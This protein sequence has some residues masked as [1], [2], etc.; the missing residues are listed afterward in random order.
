M[1]RFHVLT[2]AVFAALVFAACQQA[3]LDPAGGGSFALNT[4]VKGVTLEPNTWDDFGSLPFAGIANVPSVSGLASGG[5][6][7]V[8][9]G[10]DGTNALASRFDTLSDEWTKPVLLND[11]GLTIKPGAAHSL[12]CYYLITGASTSTTGVYSSDGDTWAT[13]GDIGFGTKAAVYGYAQQLYVV[14]GQFGQAAYATSL[15]PAEVATF[16]Q[17]S[18][19]ITGWTTGTGPALYINAGAYGAGN[20]VFGGGS[21]RIAYTSTISATTPWATAT[22]PFTEDDFINSIAYGGKDTFV[23]G[24]NLDAGGGILVYSIDGGVTWDDATVATPLILRANIYAVTYGD[25]YFVAV[26][27][28]GFIAY[29]EDGINWL[30]A[31]LASPFTNPNARVDAVVFYAA[32]NTFIAGGGDSS[33]ERVIESGF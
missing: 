24:G 13:T 9:A 11:Y 20:Y 8:A 22:V 23:A 6:Y 17:I 31:T 27:D 4:A 10:F 19:S 2:L 14:A 29:S 15:D 16:T 26:N 21:G 1:K 5:T 18:P 32:T 25:G 3:T 12:N 7:L 30:D 33:G 28:A